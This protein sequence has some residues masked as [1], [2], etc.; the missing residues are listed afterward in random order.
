MSTKFHLIQRKNPQ[1]PTE[2]KKF[3][4]QPIADGE[5]TSKEIGKEIEEMTSLT[6]P[7][8]VSALSAFR[9]IMQRK[10]SEGRIV[11]FGE[12][13]SFQVSFSSEGAETADKFEVSAIRNPK[14]IFRPG[15]DLRELLK[16][17]KYE[18]V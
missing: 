11:R 16:T 17:I 4:A 7:D 10:L 8:V 14:I 9:K 6:E 1:K 15:A 2:P 5:I 18:K 12:F 13:G 3:Y